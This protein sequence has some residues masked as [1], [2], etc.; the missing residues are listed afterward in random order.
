MAAVPTS[1]D[2][3]ADGSAISSGTARQPWYSRYAR[4]AVTQLRKVRNTGIWEPS[5]TSRYAASVPS[6]DPQTTPTGLSVDLDTSTRS[7]TNRSLS[8]G[9]ALVIGTTSTP[10]AGSATSASRI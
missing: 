2:G 9:K 7:A 10:T 5:S 1:G 4:P 8:G 6:G 3:P